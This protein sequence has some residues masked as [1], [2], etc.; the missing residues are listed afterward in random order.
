MAT[1]NDKDDGEGRTAAGG[2]LLKLGALAFFVG[3]VVGL[4]GAVFRLAL[5]QADRL[6]DQ[7]VSQAQGRTLRGSC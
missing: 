1:G 6:R 2:N 5:L 7:L 4:L 3:G